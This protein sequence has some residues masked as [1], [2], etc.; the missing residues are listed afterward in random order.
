MTEKH[1]CNWCYHTKLIGGP[2]DLWKLTGLVV[3]HKSFMDG[4]EISVSQP[5][6]FNRKEMVVT[7]KSGSKYKLEECGGNLEV[8]IG[9]ILEDIKNYKNQESIIKN[10]N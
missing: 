10:E 6:H 2:K 5:V 8:Q 7:T 4:D 9:Y 3:G 1:L